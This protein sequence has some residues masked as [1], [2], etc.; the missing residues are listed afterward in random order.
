MQNHI[1]AFD[2]DCPGVRPQKAAHKKMSMY[3][4]VC[5]NTYQWPGK[6]EVDGHCQPEQ[7]LTASREE[8]TVFLELIFVFFKRTVTSAEANVELQL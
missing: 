2:Y 8:A 7:E 4:C 3:L 1:P 5:F 6:T